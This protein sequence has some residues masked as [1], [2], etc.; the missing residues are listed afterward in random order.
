MWYQRVIEIG[1]NAAEE[2]AHN[3]TLPGRRYEYEGIEGSINDNYEAKDDEP[4]QFRRVRLKCR[5]RRCSTQPALVRM[6][7][8]QAISFR[9]ERQRCSECNKEFNR[10]CDLTKHEKTH[11]RPWKYNKPSC[12]HYQYGWP[13]EK[14]RDRHV[15]DIHSAA[16]AIYKCKYHP[17]PYESKRQSNCKQHM[18]KAHGWL[19][20]RS[21]NN[22]R[23][24]KKSGEQS[25][26][27]NPEMESYIKVSSSY[28]F[29]DPLMLGK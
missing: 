23:S 7:N 11:S 1:S 14:E 21:K 26:Y 16:P 22:S 8:G 12:K 6:K 27:R 5:A 4:G 15:N 2:T 13:T 17:C 20:V 3:N 18:E 24:T 10:P 25:S 19:Y 29:L 28:D 9:T